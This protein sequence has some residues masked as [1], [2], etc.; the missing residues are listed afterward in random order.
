MLAYW[1]SDY[2]TSCWSTA[3]E[4]SLVPMRLDAEERKKRILFERGHIMFVFLRVNVRV[5]EVLY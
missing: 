3:S 5:G 1:R 2:H 4:R